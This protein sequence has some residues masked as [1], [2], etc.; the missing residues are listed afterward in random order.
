[1][2]KS[3]L[4]AGG[5]S[6]LL[7]TACGQ[8]EN[9]SG[10]EQKEVLEMGTSA[11]F[12]PFESRNPQ[13]DI[14]GFDIDLANYIADEL[15]VE[16][17][18]TDMKFDGLIGA[19]QNDRVDLVLAGMS[20]TDTRK[21]NVDFSTEYN[22][23]GEMFVSQKGP[24]L[25]TL[26]DLEGLTVGVQLGTIQE[27]GA[28]SIIEDEGIDLE[29]KA[30]DDSGALIQ[31]ILSGRIDA[32]YMDKQVALG[33]IEVQGLDAFDDPTTASPGMA[34]AFPKGSD[35]VDEVNAVLAEMEE[36]GKL[37]ELKDKWLTDEQ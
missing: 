15:G 12:A 25:E 2:K 1:M 4:L 7:L 29:L 3:Y 33:Y 20:A 13:G 37:D 23:S 27:E 26:E 22:H 24:G 21:E 10:A 11:E 9:E 35:L 32:A 30:L 17:K 31:E 5:V 28:K 19:L 6:T 8:A 14:V 34:V 36:N 16:L 18:I